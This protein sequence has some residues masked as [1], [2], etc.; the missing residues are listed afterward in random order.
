[1]P[2]NRMKKGGKFGNVVMHMDYITI[3]SLRVYG[4]HGHYEHER[5]SEQEFLVALRVGIDAKKAAQS[6]ALTDTID[7]DLLRTIVENVF[8]G[9]PHYLLEALT[10]EI[11]RTILTE[12]IAQEVSISIQKTGVWSNGIPGI[13]ITRQK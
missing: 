10:E 6:D 1:M 5:N 12:T 11:T 2:Q 13:S 4:A 3:D 7:Y 9:R 8:K